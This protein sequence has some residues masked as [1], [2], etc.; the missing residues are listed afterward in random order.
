MTRDSKRSKWLPNRIKDTL[1]RFRAKKTSSNAPPH[2]PAPRPGALTPTDDP[3]SPLSRPIV[4]QDSSCLLFSKLPPELRREILILAFGKRSLHMGLVFD[5]PIV[6][7]PS[8]VSTGPSWSVDRDKPKSWRW[9]STVCHRNPPRKPDSVAGWIYGWRPLCY[10]EC[11]A[12]DG[13]PYCQLWPGTSPEKCQ[14]GIMGFLL[15]CR[16]A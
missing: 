15:C 7:R 12:S 5:H 14:V 1:A 9:S 3:E 8:N 4:T 11:Q 6:P 2:L 10:D 13:R 16:Q